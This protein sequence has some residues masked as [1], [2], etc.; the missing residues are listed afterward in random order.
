MPRKSKIIGNVHDKIIR[1]YESGKSIRTIVSITGIPRTSVRRHVGK[2]TKIRTCKEA[3]LRKEVNH[4]AFSVLDEN[5]FYWLGFIMADG[6]VSERHSKTII[7]S[8]Q[9]GDLA[10]VKTFKKFLGAKHQISKVNSRGSI[11]ARIAVTSDPICERLIKY[12]ITPRKSIVAKAHELLVN[13]R[14]FW[15][16]MIDGDGSI[17]IKN[18]RNQKRQV[19]IN[20][21]GSIHNITAFCKYTKCICQH[22]TNPC[23]GKGNSWQLS[24]YAHAAQVIVRHLYSD[25]GVFL[26]RKMRMAKAALK[27]ECGTK[28]NHGKH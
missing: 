21:N 3:S 14:H 12:G 18:R 15:R 8:I 23:R 26:A 9:Y 10:H 17:M 4:N 27:H 6:C 11:Q 28:K 24:L 20:L 13:N 22:S 7:L 16:G 2:C 5:T 25:C 1:L 19:V